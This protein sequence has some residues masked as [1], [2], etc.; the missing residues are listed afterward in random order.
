MSEGVL[1]LWDGHE[2]S[3]AV[4]ADGRLGFALSEE[5]VSRRKRH[6]GFPH[7][8]LARALGW[9]ERNGVTISDVALAG[10]Q[11][12]ALLRWLEPVY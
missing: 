5:R 10:R 3:A 7:L 9:A 11:G 6:S 12:R 8:A 2:A 1:G 4:V